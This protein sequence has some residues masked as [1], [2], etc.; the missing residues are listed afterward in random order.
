MTNDDK[1][2][3]VYSA[4]EA[5]E[6]DVR[7]LRKSG[8]DITKLSIVVNDYRCEE[9]IVGFYE[10][11]DRVR[12]WGVYGV[13]LGGVLGLLLGFAFSMSSR[14]GFGLGMFIE[15]LTVGLGAAVC[16]GGLGAVSAGVYSTILP[17]DSVLKYSISIE[18]VDEFQLAA[19][20]ASS[21]SAAREIIGDRTQAAWGVGSSASVRQA[22]TEVGA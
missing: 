14:A 2:V 5:A 10:R 18:T 7:T 15:P 20:D 6:S 22:R 8:Y 13:L 4:H 1:V 9:R 17:E 19:R 21:A 12:D 16:I 11:H 3:A